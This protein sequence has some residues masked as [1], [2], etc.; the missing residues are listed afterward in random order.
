MSEGTFVQSDAMIGNG[1]GWELAPAWPL[2]LWTQNKQ[3]ESGYA[4]IFAL[5]R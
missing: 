3:N 2:S 4:Y 1:Q 5:T